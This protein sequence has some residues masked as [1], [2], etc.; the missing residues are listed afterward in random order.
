MNQTKGKSLEQVAEEGGRYPVEAF[1]FVKHGLNHT[2]RQVHGEARA[3]SEGACHVSG[4]QL[5]WGLRNYAVMRYGF[6]ART[7]LGHWGI[8]RTSDFGR[9]VFAMVESKLLQKTDQDDL[10]DFDSVFDFD[11][12]FHAPVR[13]ESTA[14]AVFSL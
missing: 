14:T 11:T 9:I 1:E 13:P 5:S 2:V 8:C 4:Q 7:V 10:G 6:L 3:K 12:A